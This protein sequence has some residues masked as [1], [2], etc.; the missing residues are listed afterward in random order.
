MVENKCG[1]EEWVEISGFP[2]YE[3]SSF[4]NVRSKDRT[5]L[6]NGA[7]ANIK[8]QMLKQA[9]SRGYKRVTLYDGS[10]SK[11]RQIA[12]HRLVAEA[13][14]PNPDNLPCINHKDENPYNNHVNNLEWCTYKYN[15]NYGTAIQRRVCHQDWENIAKKQSV[16]VEQIDPDGSIV[17]VWPSMIE[18]E[19]QTGMRCSGISRCC[20]GYLKTYRGFKWRAVI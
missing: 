18:C 2:N 10:R 5:S 16:P 17:R 20:N 1:I 13:F 7:P 12:V 3:V 15:S 19:R 14:I 11:H 4:G 6:R 9:D 8:G